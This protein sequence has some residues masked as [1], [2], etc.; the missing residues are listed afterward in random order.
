[1]AVN[2]HK[3]LPQVTIET[4]RA[5]LLALKKLSD[6]APANTAIR[7]EAVTALESQLR[8]AEEAEILASKALDAA[9]DARIAAGWDLHNAMLNVKAAV[10]G[11]YGANSDAV[12]SLGLKKRIDYRRPVRRRTSAAP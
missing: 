4:D 1:M 8:Q 7:A 9:R 12:Q 2:Q 5:S 11:Q 6:Y 3:R 10:I